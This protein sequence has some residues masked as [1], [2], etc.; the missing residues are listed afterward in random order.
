M[1]LVRSVFLVLAGA[2]LVGGGIFVL[3]QGGVGERLE[4]VETRAAKNSDRL[5]Q[6][7]RKDRVHDLDIE[8]LQ[9]EVTAAKTRLGKAERRL[10]E[11]EQRLEATESSVE[12][13]AADL[14]S[15]G[16]EVASLKT[17]VDE[18]RRRLATEVRARDRRIAELEKQERGRSRLDA[19]NARRLQAI[20]EKI[21]IRPVE[22]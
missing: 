18:E 21:G 1:K 19:E 15:L 17:L 8:A 5:E 14:E 4:T 10:E 6:T 2:A 11:A 16:G 9:N 13:G 3:E 7:E 20:E 22:P 12:K